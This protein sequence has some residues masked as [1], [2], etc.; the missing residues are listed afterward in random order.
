MLWPSAVLTEMGTCITILITLFKAVDPYRHGSPF[1]VPPG[2]GSA[3]NMRIRI[4]DGKY[5][6]YKLESN[7]FEVTLHKL[8]CFLLLSNLLD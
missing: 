2:S 4:Q 3:F 8:H 7:R 1:I 5:A 6:N